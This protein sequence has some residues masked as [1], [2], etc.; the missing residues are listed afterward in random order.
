[1]NF[2]SKKLKKLLETVKVI[3]QRTNKV[4][5]CL[6]GFVEI[7]EDGGSLSDVREYAEDGS[8]A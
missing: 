8:Y 7:V 3:Q 4:K 2:F 1:L 6:T 5:T